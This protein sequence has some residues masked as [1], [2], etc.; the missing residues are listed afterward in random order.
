[1]ESHTLHHT[2]A[3]VPVVIPSIGVGLYQCP[4]GETERIVTEALEVGYRHFDTA[5]VYRNEA[6]V[7][8]A[9]R[10]SGL[11]RSA[12]FVTSKI[13]R[14][15]FG[16]HTA[17]HIQRTIEQLG[18]DYADL[19]LVHAPPQPHERLSTWEAMMEAQ[20]SGTTRSIGV[21]NYGKHHIEQLRT[22]CGVLPSVNQIEVSP[23]LQRHELT[24]YCAQHDVRIVAYSPL[25]RGKKLDDPTLVAIA[26]ATEKTPAQVLLR[27]G[28]QKGYIVI[29][30]SVNK[31]RL[32]ENFSVF[33]FHLSQQHM[34]QLDACDEGL[35]TGWD[36]TVWE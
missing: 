2:H 24:S 12:Y 36:P 26:T 11:K 20:T 6:A 9:L 35:I 31:H 33:D 21:S 18:L 8:R 15:G 22:Q 29:P 34:Q 25:T 1:M 28:L 10:A 13:W 19:L 17:D 14:D 27:W 3:S 7:G 16:P 5:A 30:K 23:Y 4:P 32:Q